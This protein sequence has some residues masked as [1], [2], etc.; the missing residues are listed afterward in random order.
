MTPSDF[1]E[2]TLD[3][4]APEGMDN[5]DPLPVF[6]DAPKQTLI[7]LW[8]PSLLERISIALFGRVWLGVIGSSHPPVWIAGK[9]RML[10]PIKPEP[11][12]PVRLDISPEAVVVAIK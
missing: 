12:E 8:R 2:K 7:S 4:Q 3:L 6:W 11:Q 9:R 10:E 1:E 5:C